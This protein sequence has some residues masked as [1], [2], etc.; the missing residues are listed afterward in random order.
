MSWK[1]NH[2]FLFSVEKDN[3]LVVVRSSFLQGQ[4]AEWGGRRTRGWGQG[5]QLEGARHVSKRRLLFF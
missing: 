3:I 5:G 2:L 4:G 1:S